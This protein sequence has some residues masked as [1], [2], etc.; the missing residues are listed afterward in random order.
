VLVAVGVAVA[1]DDLT[2][3][4]D[5]ESLGCRGVGHVEGDEA[6]TL[7]DEAVDGAGLHA[8]GAEGRSGFEVG[9]CDLAAVLARTAQRREITPAVA[10]QLADLLLRGPLA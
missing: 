3:V 8:V 6:P 1:A 5:P 2:A 9:A 4:V 10:R 7:P